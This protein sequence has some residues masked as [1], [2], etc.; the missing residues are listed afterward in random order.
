[1]VHAIFSEDYDEETMVGGDQKWAVALKHNGW[2]E[3]NP[4]TCDEHA[5]AT[6]ETLDEFPIFD[7]WKLGLESGTTGSHK[8][9][10]VCIEWKT[11]SSSASSSSS[12]S[13]R[14]RKKKKHVQCEEVDDEDETE[15]IPQPPF[16]YNTA[17]TTM[18]WTAS[19][20]SS[21]R[22]TDDNDDVDMNDVSGDM[23]E[24]RVSKERSSDSFR[25]A[26]SKAR[27]K[28]QQA[29][30]AMASGSKSMST[31]L[32]SRQD[33]SLEESLNLLKKEL[34]DLKKSTESKRCRRKKSVQF[35]HPLIESLNYRPKTLPEEM[36]RLY[37]QEDELLDWE[38]DRERTSNERF[39]V[40]LKDD[41][42][43]NLSIDC[44]SCSSTESH[45]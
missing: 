24:S 3:P 5:H 25:P 23:V 32:E 27:Y 10:K 45:L 15:Q 2:I 26:F 39:E 34:S 6:E 43:E 31:K 1:M 11:S 29:F 12:S 30:H 33:D 14:R 4:L 17:R 41:D 18:P 13:I 40:V 36:D 16:P 20:S 7:A 21:S 9:S 19:L 42:Q 37:F 28:K 22:S 44:R 35:S 38:E 8:T